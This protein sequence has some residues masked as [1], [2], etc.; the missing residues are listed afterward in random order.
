MM[1]DARHSAKQQMRMTMNAV[2]NTVM[3]AITC[4]IIKRIIATKAVMQNE[5]KAQ[6]QKSTC[7][8]TN[9]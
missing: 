5:N 2:I 1:D 6:R 7:I 9:E 3:N 8:K 4:Q